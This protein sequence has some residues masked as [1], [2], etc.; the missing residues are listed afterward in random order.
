MILASVVG[1]QG[2]QLAVVVGQRLVD[3]AEPFAGRHRLDLALRLDVLPEGDDVPAVAVRAGIEQVGRRHDRRARASRVRRDRQLADHVV[4]GRP[5]R[6]RPP[7]R[8]ARDE[9]Q[10]PEVDEHV[11]GV[12]EDDRV[13]AA[14]PVLAPPPRR[15]R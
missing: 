5:F 8:D 4:L 15:R 14:Q 10:R 1:V 6:V 3:R 2:R 9:R 13:V 11:P 7:A 12:A